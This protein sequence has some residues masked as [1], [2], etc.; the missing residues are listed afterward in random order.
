[1]YSETSE[2]RLPKMP[3]KSVSKEVYFVKGVC[4]IE[5][6]P[7]DRGLPLQVGLS[8]RVCCPRFDCVYVR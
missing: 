4:Q 6:L 2:E 5:Q 8:L 3:P 1:M 7:Q